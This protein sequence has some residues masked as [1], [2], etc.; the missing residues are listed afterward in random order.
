MISKEQIEEM[1]KDQKCG[2][3]ICPR[4]GRDTMSENIYTNALSRHADVY[5]CDDCG[6]DEG[7]RVFV[8]EVLPF[9]EWA[10][11]KNDTSV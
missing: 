6:I 11:I 2:D 1:L 7:M 8:D 4:C 10:I 9:E 5:V 3:K